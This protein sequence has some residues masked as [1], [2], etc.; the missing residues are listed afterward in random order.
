[1]MELY[2]NVI[3]TGLGYAQSWFGPAL[4]T[5]IFTLVKTSVLIMCIVAPLLGAVAYSFPFGKEPIAGITPIGDMIAA[6]STPAPRAA[7][8]RA[9]SR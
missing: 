2:T 3:A 1:M 9:A 7:S 5:A 6:T 8:T 4:G